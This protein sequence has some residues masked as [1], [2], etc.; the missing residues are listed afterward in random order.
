MR[1]LVT[2]IGGPAGRSLCA[3]LLQRGHEAVGADTERV[4]LIDLSNF[5]RS[6][7]AADVGY[8]RWL[9][10]ALNGIDLL[11]P[12]THDELPKV[13]VWRKQ[14]P[15]PALIGSFNGVSIAQDKWYTAQT[16]QKAG[17]AIP[18]SALPSHLTSPSKVEQLLGWPCLSKP[19]SG[20]GGYGV[21]IYDSPDDFT[22]LTRLDDTMIVQQ[23]V[24][25]VEYSVNL[26][27]DEIGRATVVVLE[28][29]ALCHG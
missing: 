17:I 23:F 5:F 16:L 27:V 21:Q 24:P 28:K 14:L 22:Q 18:A 15:C 8:E 12:T 25:S 4:D 11:I 7:P 10:A 2:G 26:T 9:H 1:I 3:L 6:P 29:L 13:A 19:R 20:Y